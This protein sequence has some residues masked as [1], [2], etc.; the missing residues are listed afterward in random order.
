MVMDN[1]YAISNYVGQEMTNPLAYEATH[2]G[3][4]GWSDNFVVGNVYAEVEPIKGLKL[5]SDIGS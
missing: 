1:P 2:Q 4:Y 5:K 3:N